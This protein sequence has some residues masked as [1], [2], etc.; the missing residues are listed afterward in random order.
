MNVPS[1]VPQV[2]HQ[3]AHEL[4]VAVLD[5]DCSAQ[6]AY[7]LGD[8][9]AEN[10]APHRRLSCSTLAHQEHLALLLALC[11]VHLAGDVEV[12]CRRGLRSESRLGIEV[13]LGR[14]CWMLGVI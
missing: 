1:T 6:S 5:I 4:D 9:V 13:E 11:R 14:G 2:Q 7:V 12:P 8:I 10:D 3:V